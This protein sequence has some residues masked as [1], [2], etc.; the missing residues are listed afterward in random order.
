MDDAITE[1][2]EQ[3]NALFQEASGLKDTTRRS[4]ALNDA[5]TAASQKFEQAAGIARELL[6]SSELPDDVRLHLEVYAPYYSYESQAT[7]RGWHYE[8]HE[9]A[10][11]EACHKRARTLLDEHTRQIEAKLKVASEDNRSWLERTQRKA[12]IFRGQDEVVSL[13][14]AA[15]AAWDRGDFIAALDQY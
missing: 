14:I 10:D 13:S 11:A 2:F 1:K 5:N 4:P 8:R 15:R 9:T 7:L 6:A 12:D 3:L